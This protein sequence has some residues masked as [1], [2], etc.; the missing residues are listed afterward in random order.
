MGTHALVAVVLT[1]LLIPGTPVEAQSGDAARIIAA[2]EKLEPSS[3]YDMHG[4]VHNQL[5]ALM[6][7]R[8]SATREIIQNI[9][10]FERAK[11]LPDLVSA[12]YDVLGFVKDP[13]AIDWLRGKVA[14]SDRNFF[15]TR[16]LPKW[17]DMIE[18]YGTWEWL[19]ERERWIQLFYRDLRSG[20]EQCQ[21]NRYPQSARGF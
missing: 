7:D 12:L 17:H 10:R 21:E 11:Q 8:F 2:L 4:N 5:Q 19:E 20:G 9:D 13:A 15:Y 16:Y 18:G 3:Y 6:I 14:E 1:V